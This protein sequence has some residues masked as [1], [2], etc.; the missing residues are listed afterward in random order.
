MGWG[1]LIGNA[2]IAGFVGLAVLS[3]KLFSLQAPPASP[4]L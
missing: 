3:A 2:F 4:N 1:P